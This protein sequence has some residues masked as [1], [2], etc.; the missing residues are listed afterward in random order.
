MHYE[1]VREVS[2][3]QTVAIHWRCA[4]RQIG[5]W[6]PVPATGRRIEWDGVHF[7][8][9]RAGKIVNLWAMADTFTKAVQLGGELVP[10]SG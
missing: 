10:P 4:A 8:T 5:P 3:G 2:D 7:I 6:G 9:V 1:V